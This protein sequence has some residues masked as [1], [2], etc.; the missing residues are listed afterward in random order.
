MEELPRKIWFLWM[1]GLPAAPRVV[2]DCHESWVA[3]NPGWE[4]MVLDKTNIGDHIQTDFELGQLKQLPLNQKADLIRLDLLAQYGGV[5][6]DATCYCMRPLDDWLGEAMASGFF[7]FRRP[8]PDRLISSWFLAAR[9][10]HVLITRWY[11]MML[12]YWGGH[13]FRNDE[14]RAVV[15]VVHGALRRS[16]RL[17]RFWFSPV[18]RDWLSVSPYFAVH[19]AFNKLVRSDASCAVAWRQTR[20]ISSDVARGLFQGV[21]PL[22]LTPALRT[23]IDSASAPLYKLNWRIEALPEESAMAYL[24]RAQRTR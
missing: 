8:G 12:S 5:W 10:A 19:Y 17:T 2:R 20:Y 11:A 6:A 16:D 9:P 15:R 13:S 22:P 7:A 21:L 3:A 24:L 14:R 23:E 18:V 4:V 1:Q